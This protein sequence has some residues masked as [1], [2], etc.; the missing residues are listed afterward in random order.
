MRRLSQV[1]IAL[2]LFAAGCR[3]TDSALKVTVTLEADGAR[4]VIGNCVKL[5]VRDGDD[6]LNSVILPRPDGRD[7][8][9]GVVHGELPDTVSLQASVWLGDCA[10]ETTLALNARGDAVSATFPE[11]EVTPVTV[12][13]KPPGR[14][15][16]ADADGYV[17]AAFGGPD[18]NDA[19]ATVFP[20]ATQ[21]CLSQLDDDC[22]GLVGCDDTDDCATALQCR[23]PPDRVTLQ[24]E[25]QMVSR[26][27][28][29]KL[30]VG[31]ADATGPRPAVR[32]T[33]V[34]LSSPGDVTFHHESD[35]LPGSVI[36]HVDFAFQGDA[37]VD[38]W[39][40]PGDTATGSVELDAVGERVAMPGVTSL[41]VSIFP[42]ANLRFTNSPLT[43]T[44]G[45]C[46]ATPLS[47]QFVDAQG[48]PTEVATNT[49]VTLQV[50]PQDLEGHAVF[51]ADATCSTAID[52][53]VFDAGQG[54]GQV[55]VSARL[56]GPRSLTATTGALSA[57]QALTV[58]PAV[59]SKLVFTNGSTPTVNVGQCA[60]ATLD[61]ALQD[62][63][64]NASTS[65]RTLDLQLSTS[66]A[67]SF[68]TAAG[69]GSGAQST[70]Q[71][72]IG[73]S[74]LH[75]YFAAAQNAQGTPTVSVS[76]LSGAIMGASTQV[77]VSA[78][79]PDSFRWFPLSQTLTAGS[80]S[81]SPELLQV[82]RGTQLAPAPV[83]L[84]FDLTI[85]GVMP[86]NVELYSAAGCAASSRLVTPRVTIG[87][88]QSGV[89][90]YFKATMPSAGFTF[91]A[92][93]GPGDAG[94]G[95][96]PLE[97]QPNRIVPAAPAVL[98][99]DTASQTTA[100]DQCSG[101]F[102]FHLVD[103]YG[104]ATSFP[105]SKTVTVSS[106]VTSV[107]AGNAT[108]GQGDTVTL[109]ADAGAGTFVATAHRTGTLPIDVSIGALTA[110]GTLQVTPGGVVD[111]VL[112][113]GSPQ[114]AG[115]CFDVAWLRRDQFQNDAPQT[116]TLSVSVAPDAGVE[117]FGSGS[118]TGASAFD[119]PVSNLARGTFSMKLHRATPHL[120]QATF[121]GATGQRS[122]SVVPGA[123]LLRV[124]PGLM[125]VDAGACV[126]LNL[127]L[128]DA[129]L[130][131]VPR[132]SD[133]TVT[134]VTP[135]GGSVFLD[136]ACGAA[137]PVVVPSGAASLGVWARSTLSGATGDPADDV[138]SFT[139]GNRADVTLRTMPGP[140]DHLA[141]SPTGFV[142][143]APMCLA[144]TVTGRDA[145]ENPVHASGNPL[146][147][148]P[149]VQAATYSDGNCLLPATSVTP[150]ASGTQGTFSL[151]ATRA[152]PHSV[153]VLW[154]GKSASLTGLVSPGAATQLAFQG[155]PDS[156]IAGTCSSV[157][158]LVRRDAQGND[159]DGG[160]QSATLS[161]AGLQAFGG[162]TCGAPA[163][164]AIPFAAGATTSD[165]F[166]LQ[167]TQ[168][169]AR[170]LT[171]TIAAPPASGSVN[172]T[173]WAA[174][175]QSVRLTPATGGSLQA[176]VCSAALT[177][178][179]L[180][181]FSNPVAPDAGSLAVALASD[182]PDASVLFYA[183]A[184][185]SGPP[186]TSV[187][188]SGGTPA[189]SFVFLPVQARATV[190]SA[191]TPA[192]V[193]SQSWSVTAAP[194]S[195]AVFLALPPTSL[196]RF[197]CT[198]VGTLEARDSWD[199]PTTL[200]LGG[201][202]TLGSSNPTA[203]VTFYADAACSAAAPATFATGTLPLY[204]WASG[205]GTTDLTGAVTTP[206]VSLPT[207]T[208]TVVDGAPGALELTSSVGAVEAG[209]C[210]P[211]T[212]TRKVAG[213]AETRGA[214]DVSFSVTPDAGLSL[215]A[216]S[217]CSGPQAQ[218]L[219]TSIVGGSASASLYVHGQSAPVVAATLTAHDARGGFADGTLA[220]TSL[221]L[222]RR[223]DCDLG[224]DAGA[225]SC[226]LTPP[227]PD[228]ALG[229]SM[230]VFSA[231][232]RGA[233]GLYEPQYSH[234]E[235][236]LAGDGGAESV[237]CSRMT[238]GS[239]TVSVAWQVVSYGRPASAGGLTV[240][241]LPQNALAVDAGVQLLPL[242]AAV[243]LA[244]SF[245]LWSQASG[246][247][248]GTTSLYPLVD[249]N[250]A[251]LAVAVTAV[252][253]QESRLLSAQVVTLP[254]TGAVDHLVVQGLPGDAGTF[255]VNTSAPATGF[256]LVSARL[257]SGTQAC[258]ARFDTTVS[259]TQ[260]QV[261]RGGT[262]AS[263]V[264]CIGTPVDALSVQRVAFPG[265]VAQQ[266]AP[267]T[268]AMGQATAVT[269]PA[270]S[271]VVMDRTVVLLANQGPGGQAGG[272]S[273]SH[274]NSPRDDEVAPFNAVVKLVD[275]THVSVLR[276]AP[277]TSDSSFFSP[278]VVQLAPP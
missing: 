99:L 55:W 140:L 51:Y 18:C 159:T 67:L 42:V 247:T 116:G 177:V 253:T 213:V 278:M 187:A 241:H 134:V 171:A 182:S 197:T 82:T 94:I 260:V 191:T 137:G 53:L 163:L 151:G 40:R 25:R 236:H 214:L 66:G 6:E 256:A 176:G 112:D 142:A 65:S 257:A 2:F 60:L 16:D 264:E 255:T 261:D 195:K 170:G 276:G 128:A 205:S 208:V 54:L 244:N 24:L 129:D 272:Q 153:S 27:E 217:D 263:F 133:G 143:P 88:G 258:G 156:L 210:Q 97:S 224:P 185:C 274:P 89:P 17:S 126:A 14:D 39:V 83:D 73:E 32:D 1:S 75:V 28:C 249:L 22:D 111:L 243:S 164:S 240:K 34:A 262:P 239:G 242:G 161:A 206:S 162:A 222:V 69:C 33:R 92:T 157:V 115:Q 131:P 174:P 59:P 96:Q 250:D 211:V 209:G 212:V 21:N 215:H 188:L 70:F 275:E 166:Y 202:L 104:N 37:T 220:L 47:L 61:L 145:F 130:N 226:V 121:A 103:V 265:A 193:A 113:A 48:L 146:S 198:L 267:V 148:T 196:T 183:G 118:C 169:G 52:H 178:Q 138:F 139:L 49:S 180:D 13:V 19:A 221:P 266:L 72:P 245:V 181:Q 90:F 192:G 234:V 11:R 50:D 223:G 124:S 189:P 76:A 106:Q 254:P 175:A 7:L 109:A 270:F 58:R 219:T 20:G 26:R 230:L 107:L 5:S 252:P 123:P 201:A 141:L 186:V 268:L 15:L 63:F 122:V 158:T 81:P 194:F 87:Q 84:P 74:A 68:F 31:L 12:T 167:G 100:A 150:P 231:T 120:V 232:G 233:T 132:T 98:V 172:A 154:D 57:T 56:T 165:P 85:G 147:L 78:G 160:A 271:P 9:V 259:A 91:I 136:P 62:A 64:G 38:A 184:A 218:A 77:Q 216:A 110:P 119:F 227:I 29:V 117:V 46:A 179:Q 127:T 79:P 168:A 144:V 86:T 23:N 204:A 173:I 30:T 114:T 152:G 235:C 277:A 102:S 44:A 108:C 248:D 237:D 93:P 45:E 105:V 190:I 125:T 41:G 8:V 80:C 36:D 225:V 199:N 155:A 101:P 238:A 203:G 228:H 35:C 273:A 71:L 95:T 43:V 3:R 207:A 200:G 149:D 10:D 229:R 269:S 246:G 135:T 4:E 251:G